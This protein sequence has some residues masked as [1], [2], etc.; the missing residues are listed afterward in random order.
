LKIRIQDRENPPELVEGQYAT[1]APVILFESVNTQVNVAKAT[2]CDKIIVAVVEEVGESLLGFQTSLNSLL[3]DHWTN[4][5]LEYII[6][7][8]NNNSRSYDHAQELVDKICSSLSEEYLQQLNLDPVL[9]GFHAVSKNAVTALVNGIFSDLDVAFEK[10]F[11]PGWYESKYM[12]EVAQHLD[13][14]FGD[15]IQSYIQESFMRRFVT[16]CLERLVLRYLQE[17]YN[18]KY[19]TLLP[20]AADKM[21][22]DINVIRDVFSKYA[23]PQQVAAVLQTLEDIRELLDS[24]E[25]MLGLYFNGLLTKNPDITIDHVAWILNKRQDLDSNKRKE[26]LANCK[27]VLE[28]RAN[29]KEAP[30]GKGGI[31]SQIKVPK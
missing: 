7:L 1:M 22:D 14:E 31:F 16:E 27:T 25:E 8:V 3:R 15:N 18:K 21:N 5:E 29:S 19:K 30:I 23:R 24:E 28:K 9:D 20:E 10:L 6:A 26:G 12:K 4:L 13:E 17:L 2:K 11:L